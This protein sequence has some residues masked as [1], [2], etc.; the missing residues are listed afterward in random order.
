MGARVLICAGDVTAE[1]VLNDSA[2]ARCISAALPLEGVALRWG[3]EIYFSVPVDC[4]PDNPQAVVNKGDLG[5]WVP[6]KAICIFFGPT[7]A[8]RS[9]D[10]IRPASPVNIFG[11]IVGDASVFQSVKEGVKVRIEP[12]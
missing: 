5:Y 7:P 10:E 2:T 12:L 8:S 11:H 6:G 3:D 1:A 4:P 9:P